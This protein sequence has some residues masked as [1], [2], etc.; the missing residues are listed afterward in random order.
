M[1]DRNVVGEDMDDRR[2]IAL[3]AC[4]EQFDQL[5]IIVE[6]IDLSGQEHRDLADHIG[7][8]GIESVRDIGSDGHEL[9]RGG[10][11]SGD[12]VGPS[13]AVNDVSSCLS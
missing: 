7:R 8:S 1:L 6:S 2:D 5:G 4:L 12:A 11:P 10:V 3:H 13:A 9:G